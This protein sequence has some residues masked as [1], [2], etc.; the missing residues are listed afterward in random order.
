MHPPLHSPS[1][2]HKSIPPDGVRQQSQH[3][4]PLPARRPLPPLQH[5]PLPPLLH[6]PPSSPLWPGPFDRSVLLLFF[7]T[8]QH[9]LLFFAN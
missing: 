7:S 1:P 4:P 6:R 9:F 2:I 3:P 5:Q 8:V